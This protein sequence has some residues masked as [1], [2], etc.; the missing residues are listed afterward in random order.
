MATRTVRA[1]PLCLE[2][3]GYTSL[4]KDLPL[5]IQILFDYVSKLSVI[6]TYTFSR[7]FSL[8]A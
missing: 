5:S 4:E 1:K 2:G 6:I 3:F 7:T 8:S